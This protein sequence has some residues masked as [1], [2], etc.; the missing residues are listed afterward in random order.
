VSVD[1]VGSKD[2]DEY[3][4]LP[5]QPTPMCPLIRLVPRT[6]TAVQ[7]T[8]YDRRE[9]PLIRLVP[10]TATTAFGSYFTAR[11]VSVDQVGSKDSD[12]SNALA[13]LKYSMCP[14]IRLVPRTAT[15]RGLPAIPPRP[16]C[17]LIRLVPRTA[18][19]LEDKIARDVYVSVD[20]VGSK[21]SD[22]LPAT[23]TTS[24]L[25]CPLIRLVPRTATPDEL[26]SVSDLIQ[27]SVDQ[28]GSKDSD[29]VTRTGR[30][31]VG[32]VSVDQVGSKDSDFQS[33][34]QLRPVF[35]CPLIRLVPRTAT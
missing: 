28:V 5:D 25:K 27:V 1:Q 24:H 4:P 31:V 6:A 20:Q 26:L 7:L 12:L 19:C 32:K 2:S 30:V 18:T 33:L 22:P 13:I 16:L 21:D 23:R 3:S 15:W 10:R 14:L 11:Q 34:K 9:C 8:E 35:L 17:P 29:I